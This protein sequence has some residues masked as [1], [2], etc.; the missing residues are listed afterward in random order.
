MEVAKPAKKVTNDIGKGYRTGF[1]FSDLNVC[2][3]GMA[4]E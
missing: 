3:D 4:L 2:E 1:K